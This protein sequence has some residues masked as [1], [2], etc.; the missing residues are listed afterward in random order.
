MK[1]FVIS[2][3]IPTADYPLNGIFEFDQAKALA[4]IG[5]DTSMLVIDFRSMAYKRKFGLFS[6]ERDGV[7]VFELSLP[8][9]VY[10]RAM[11]VLQ[12]LLL[13]L[14]RKAVKK[15][16]KPDVVHAH[17]YSIAA[18]ASIIKKKE[19]VPFF[20][21]EHS[22]KLN[23]DAALIS[24]LDK[25]LAV[26]AYSNADVVIAVSKSLSRNLKNN[27]G[28]DCSVINN[29]VDTTFFPYLEYDN[30]QGFVFLS[31][32]NLVPVKGFDILIKAFHK[33]F[34][35]ENDVFLYIAG[36][37][38]ERNHL[39]D[40]INQYNIDDRVKLLGQKP[41][42]E[43]SF[44]MRKTNVFVLA[45]QSETFGVVYIEAMASG[46]PVIATCCGGPEDFVNEKNGVLVPVNDIDALAEAL[47]NMRLSA[48]KYD[49][50]KISQECNE[51]FSPQNIAKEIQKQYDK[52]LAM[53]S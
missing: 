47:I 12:R 39:Q 1:S 36:D 25:Q 13:F 20:I 40:V 21:T 43:L 48:D 24:E 17:F 7:K 9:G 10:R 50:L 32:G 53:N 23:K 42:H 18:I 38:V 5:V 49:G 52:V 34:P 44:L 41:R 31:V 8:L 16:G 11:P 29:I 4:E 37:G 15:V 2:R 35:N 33:A 27:F 28:I 45:S 51:R 14:Y 30:N 22:S 26:K 19:K 6:Y 46:R 3:G